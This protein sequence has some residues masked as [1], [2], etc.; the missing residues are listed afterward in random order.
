M[1]NTKITKRKNCANTT[2]MDSDSD[3]GPELPL[4]QGNGDMVDE[5]DELAHIEKCDNLM[6][7]LKALNQAAVNMSTVFAVS[8]SPFVTPIITPVQSN[9]EVGTQF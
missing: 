6:A 9:V 2:Q 3:S 7:Q 4:N 1:A 8:T 5:S